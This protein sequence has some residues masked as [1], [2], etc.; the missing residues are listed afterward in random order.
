MD[1]HA[2]TPKRKWKHSLLSSS[3]PLEFEI[4]K[5][6]ASLEFAIDADYTFSRTD[7]GE[8]KDFSVDIFA[9]KYTRQPEPDPTRVDLLILVECKFRTPQKR[10]LFLHVNPSQASRP[11]KRHKHA[12]TE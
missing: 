8:T 5:L 1:D 7:A 3:L 4:A 12:I 6:L 10:W 11:N 9:T 2:K